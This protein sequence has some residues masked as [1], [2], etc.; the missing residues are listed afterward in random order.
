MKQACVKKLTRTV[1]R[2]KA[3]PKGPA[4]TSFYPVLLFTRYARYGLRRLFPAQS[5]L[6]D[7][8][9]QPQLPD[10]QDPELHPPPLLIGFCEVIPKPERGPASI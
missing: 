4:F 3:D 9:Y 6:A 7:S 10:P 2:K 5:A 8:G 1:Q